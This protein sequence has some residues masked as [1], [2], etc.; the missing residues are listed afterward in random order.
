MDSFACSSKW[1]AINLSSEAH[2]TALSLEA[3]QFAG[4]PA[5]ELVGRP[6]AQIL[7]A[8]SAQE[9]PQMLDM[10][11]ESGYWVGDVICGACG[12]MFMEARGMM[13]SMA[14]KSNSSAGYLLM[15]TPNKS[16][17][18]NQ[19]ESSALTEVAGTLRALAHDLNNPLAVMMGFSQL[20]VMNENCHGQ[21]RN[22]IEKIYAE[23]KRVIQVV[24]RLQ[25]YA[26]SLYQ[27]PDSDG[28]SGNFVRH[29]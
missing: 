15:L 3:E 10:A 27:K 13:F 9:V 22:D 11:T 2:I 28:A 29:A 16:F 17:A 20:L 4:Y 14:G 25:E 24:E 23:L 26:R 19:E 6:L 7:D 5:Q 12:G 18:L 21:V 1:L 8:K